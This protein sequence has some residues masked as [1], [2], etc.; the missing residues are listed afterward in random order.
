[1]PL[2]DHNLE[3]DCYFELSQGEERID[4]FRTLHHRKRSNPSS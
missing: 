1:M 2:F 3:H 4:I